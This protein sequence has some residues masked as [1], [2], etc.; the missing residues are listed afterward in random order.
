MPRTAP[1]GE[2][3]Q[4]LVNNPRHVIGQNG[5]AFR[6][7]GGQR[8]SG[9]DPEPKLI[10]CCSKDDG[11]NPDRVSNRSNGTAL[12]PGTIIR[13]RGHALHVLTSGQLTLTGGAAE[14]SA[15]THPKGV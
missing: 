8:R 14:P 9:V 15:V 13:A 3:E 10:E 11:Q 7:A 5:V 6:R 12:E 1:Y 2:Q 4:P